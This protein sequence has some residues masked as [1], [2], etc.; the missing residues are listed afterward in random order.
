MGNAVY[1]TYSQEDLDLQY[2]MRRR[3]PHFAETFA[4]MEGHN[5]RTVERFERSCQTDENRS[6]QG[7]QPCPLCR[8]K[9]TPLGESSG[10]VQLEVC[11]GI[12][13]ALRIEMIEYRGVDG[14]EFL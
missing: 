4:A 10:A 1:D 14:G 8:A 2:D 7:Q 12:E 6:L 3:C 5:R 13:T 11:S 9:L